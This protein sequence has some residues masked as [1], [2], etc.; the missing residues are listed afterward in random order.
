MPLLSIDYI[1]QCFLLDFM[2]KI[3]KKKLPLHE[4]HFV[5]ATAPFKFLFILVRGTLSTWGAGGVRCGEIPCCS[6]PSPLSLLR[7]H[8]GTKLLYVC[9]I[10]SLSTDGCESPTEKQQSISPQLRLFKGSCWKLFFGR[11]NTRIYLPPAGQGIFVPNEKVVPYQ[12][13]SSYRMVINNI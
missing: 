7:T 1:N 3:D 11:I 12:I 6:R 5:K 13:L 10:Q 2:L 9:D 8:S 4:S